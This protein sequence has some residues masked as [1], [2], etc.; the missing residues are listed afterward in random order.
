MSG[1]PNLCQRKCSCPKEFH[2]TRLVVLTG[3]PGAGKTAILEMA[4]KVLC[5]HVAILPEAASVVYG[6]GFWRLP[7]ETARVSAQRAIYHVQREMESLVLLERKWAIGLCDRGTLDGTA[8][9]PLAENLYWEA[10]GTSLAKELERY[11]A[12]I[13]LR[14]PAENLGYNH[15]NPLRIETSRQ[16][17]E[18]DLAIE[19]I[20]KA[21][22]NYRVIENSQSFI[23]KA[24]TAIDLISDYLPN[25][26]KDTLK[27]ATHAEH[28]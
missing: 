15:E 6:G 12:V 21:H 14:S 23:T 18:I 11:L 9:W 2:D 26:C 27:E 4:K 1:A 22:P 25:C 19:R 16:A 17:Q 20:W 13:H 24:Q 8:Y 3:G 10:T 7:S 28:A 5:E